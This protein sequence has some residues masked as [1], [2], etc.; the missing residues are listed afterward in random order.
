MKYGIVVTK[1]VHT[2]S[3]HIPDKIK[4]SEIRKGKKRR[5]KTYSRQD[6]PLV[7][8]VNTDCPAG[9]LIAVS[10]RVLMHSTSYGRTWKFNHWICIYA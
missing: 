3:V 4:G 7:T 8:H 6:S 2:Y 1:L 5:K 9:C 10:R